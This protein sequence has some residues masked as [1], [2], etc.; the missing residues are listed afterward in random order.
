MSP[1]RAVGRGVGWGR[2]RWP[3][4][5]ATVLIAIAL[6]AC[7]FDPA[8]SIGPTASAQVTS[9]AAPSPNGSSATAGG[10]D[11]D[12]GDGGMLTVDLER[13]GFALAVAIQPDG[14][15]IA[16]GDTEAEHG[17]DI[18]VV[19]CLA[20]GRL[21]PTF[22]GGGKVETDLGEG[23]DSDDHAR[24]VAIQPDGKIVV[25][26]FSDTGDVVRGSEIAVV[27]YASDGLLDEGF[28]AGGRL[29]TGLG[30]GVHDAGQ[31]VAIQPDGGILVAGHTSGDGRGFDEHDFVLVRYAPDGSL[32][33][34]FGSG[35][36][37][38]TDFGGSDD[39]AFDLALQADGKIVVSGTSGAGSPTEAMAR[40]VAMARYD[41]DGTLDRE[42]GV[43]GKVTT[44]LDGS[45]EG[46]GMAIQADGGIVLVTGTGEDVLLA[47]FS[48]SGMPDGAFGTGGH[49]TSDFGGF[50]FAS[51]VAIQPDGRIIVAAAGRG[52][53]ILARYSPDG[54]IDPGF[55]AGE[56]PTDF[57]VP[58]WSKAVAL[59]PDG[60]IIVAGEQ[61]T[62][63]NPL[64][65]LCIARFRG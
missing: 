65:D 60:M 43:E 9:A 4:A 31:A 28:G 62:R 42:F 45:D 16:A 10:L 64:P 3:G 41:A 5:A 37:V 34:D 17:G 22:G 30:D 14:K 54:R 57:G 7:R 49:V 6:V 53:F 2:R 39:L 44:A 32:D 56:L 20:D 27:R 1:G 18:V 46:V 35:G 36:T 59:Q 40:T 24:A 50:D 12:F 23:G 29:L 26:G 63:A 61:E 21:D 47:R 8:G 55:G 11:R 38:R 51:S 58:Y 19:R 13:W 48:R 33:P 25:V 52:D 15:I